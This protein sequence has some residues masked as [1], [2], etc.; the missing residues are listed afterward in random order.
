MNRRTI[1]VTGGAGHVGS[2][3]IELLVADDWKALLWAQILPKVKV[4]EDL[5]L[6]ADGHT[7]W[8]VRKVSP[9]LEIG[10]AHV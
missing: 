3:V 2:H 5:V 8:G 4:R 1:L 7:G 9:K 10:R 6:R